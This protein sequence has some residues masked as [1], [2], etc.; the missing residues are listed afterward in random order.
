MEKEEPFVFMLDVSG[1]TGGSE[2]YWTTTNEIFKQ[3]DNQISHYYQWDTNIKEVSKEEMENHIKNKRGGGGTNPHLVA[4]EVVKKG[5]K[6]IILITDGQVSDNDVSNCDQKLKDF[7]F[8]KSICYVVA[9]SSETLNMS[10]TCPFTRECPNEVYEKNSNAPITKMI[11]LAEEDL[12]ILDTLNTISLENF[13][14]NFEKIENVIITLNMGKESNI[15]LKNQLVLLKNRIIKEMAKGKS[16]D[17]NVG[18]REALKKGDFEKAIQIA[19]AF[20]DAYLMDSMTND[21]EKRI[22]HLITLCGD[23]RG[24][25]NIHQ[26]K[27]NKMDRAQM[28]DPSELNLSLKPFDIST[29]PIQCPIIMDEDVPQILV[30]ECEPILLG[31]E[32]MVVDDITACMPP[33]IAWIP[34]SKGQTQGATEQIHWREIC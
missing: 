18:L 34:I 21:V 2:N 9:S 12:A 27:S 30:D 7:K 23:L 8:T 28:A 33:E 10:V 16:K 20:N 17:I 19:K 13:E 15:P 1:S 31:L 22:N 25:Y 29:S 24:K 5:Y 4:D 6:K 26:I 3:F 14:I 11:S 32:K